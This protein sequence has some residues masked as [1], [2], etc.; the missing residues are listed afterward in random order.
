VGDNGG[1]MEIVVE[2]AGGLVDM[3]CCKQLAQ[4]VPAKEDSMLQILREGLLKLKW[5]VFGI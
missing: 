5:M 3:E 4:F 1:G 2:E